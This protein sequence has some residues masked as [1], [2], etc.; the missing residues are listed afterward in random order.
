VLAANLPT[1]QL[2]HACAPLSGMNFP[3]GQNVQ[4]DTPAAL[5]FPATHVSHTEAP[6]LV[7]NFPAPHATHAEALVPEMYP[8]PQSVH[9]CAPAAALNFPAPHAS[10]S[11]S[12][13]I[14]HFARNPS[15]LSL[16]MKST[17]S[18]PLVATSCRPT[19]RFACCHVCRFSSHT[20]QNESR[21]PHTILSLDRTVSPRAQSNTRTM[22]YCR[23]LT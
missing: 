5:N 21:N 19:K 16:L 8:A 23:M 17:S 15:P 9:A 2:L 18:A 22:S 12:S 3:L 20:P 4:T 13:D 14:R 7:T 6:V 10:H 1:G 11:M